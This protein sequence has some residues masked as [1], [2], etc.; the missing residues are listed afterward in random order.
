M[1]ALIFSLFFFSLS[2]R[3]PSKTRETFCES[4]RAR[5]GDL[6]VVIRVSKSSGGAT[7]K[8]PSVSR[9]GGLASFSFSARPR[10]RIRFVVLSLSLSLSLT[11]L[12]NFLSLS[13]SQRDQDAD[14]GVL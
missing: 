7:K 12:S 1:R 9:D 14:S 10:G 8:R 13:L 4:A 5:A 11:Q 6:S 3:A 2:R